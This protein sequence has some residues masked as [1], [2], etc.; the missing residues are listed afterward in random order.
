MWNHWLVVSVSANPVCV[1]PPTDARILVVDHPTA[2]P[3]MNPVASLSMKLLI[4]VAAVCIIQKLT[5]L[6]CCDAENPL[7]MT[8]RNG[9]FDWSSISATWFSALPGLDTVRYVG[10][11]CVEYMVLRYGPESASGSAPSSPNL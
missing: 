11:P 8:S 2:N 1:T 3:L 10:V 5:V 7:Q 6:L 4:V 9:V